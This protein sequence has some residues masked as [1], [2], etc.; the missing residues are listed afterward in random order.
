MALPAGDWTLATAL[1]DG[2]R[3]ALQLG[4]GL[5]SYGFDRY[6]ARTRAPARLV[7]A[8]PDAEAGDI[9]A[10]CVRV[11]DLVNTPTQDMGPDELEAAARAMAEAH[12]A[13][14][15]SI[16]G[17]DLLA[18]DFPAIHAVGRDVFD[19]L[20]EAPGGRGKLR[21]IGG[22]AELLPDLTEQL[23]VIGA[24]QHRLHLDDGRRHFTHL[25]HLEQ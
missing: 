1:D 9:L 24:E 16:V 8:A 4:W 18:Q 21:I 10:A 3:H 2:A 17:D 20:V 22:F 11:R 23:D 6:K 14:F 15:E 12:G 13:S 5:G 19:Q 25:P 7:L